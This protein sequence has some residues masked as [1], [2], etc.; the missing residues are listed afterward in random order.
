M[1]LKYVLV[2]M[3]LFV[4]TIVANKMLVLW[5]CVWCG[6]SVGQVPVLRKLK[7]SHQFTGKYIATSKSEKAKF[8]LLLD[9]FQDD[10]EKLTNARLYSGSVQSDISEIENLDTNVE[11]KAAIKY[12]RV[13][14]PELRDWKI[15]KA[16]KRILLATGDGGQSQLKGEFKDENGVVHYEVNYGYN[17]YLT[18]VPR[19]GKVKEQH[20][21]LNY[22]TERRFNIIQHTGALLANELEADEDNCDRNAKY[23]FRIMSYNVWNVNP[24]NDVFG[25]QLRWR[26]YTKR[27]DWF[28]KNVKNAMADIIGFQEVRHDNTFGDKGRHHQIKVCRLGFKT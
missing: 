27:M 10:I 8:P 4:T 22:D 12:L 6:L 16:R 24:G 1:V 21:V 17:L 3:H 11:I 25:E 9:N 23:S 5:F 13:A 26:Q 28:A 7:S 2:F 19:K 15:V 20:L 18:F 14:K